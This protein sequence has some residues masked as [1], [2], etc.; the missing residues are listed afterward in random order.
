MIKSDY[1]SLSEFENRSTCSGV[2][3]DFKSGSYSSL[4]S[5]K[6]YIDYDD[7]EQYVGSGLFGDKYKTFYCHRGL[8]EVI[9]EFHRDIQLSMSSVDLDDSAVH[10]VIFL[11]GL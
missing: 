6:T 1:K 8:S 11:L 10:C 5:Y 7:F 4:S 9:S 3:A 2:W